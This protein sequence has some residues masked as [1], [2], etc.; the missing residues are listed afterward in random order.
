[1]WL[2]ANDIIIG[3]AVGSFLINNSTYVAAS[4]HYYLD[5]HIHLLFLSSFAPGVIYLISN[6]SYLI[7]LHG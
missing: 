4:L 3:V 2:V 1:M 5:V 6:S 7:A